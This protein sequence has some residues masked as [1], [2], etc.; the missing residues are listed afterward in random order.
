MVQIGWDVLSRQC[1]LQKV[2][3][4]VETGQERA[5]R[6]R[7]HDGYGQDHAETGKRT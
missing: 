4:G 1:G 2:L 7:R 6:K 5:E 3:E